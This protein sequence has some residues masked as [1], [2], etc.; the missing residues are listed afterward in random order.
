MHYRDALAKVIA[1]MSID[2]LVRESTRGPFDEE[3]LRREEAA[4]RRVDDAKYA[5][6]ELATRITEAR[7]RWNNL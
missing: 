1:D 6:E 4:R 5:L 7:A 3:L 2:D